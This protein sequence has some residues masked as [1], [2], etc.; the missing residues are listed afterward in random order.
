MEFVYHVYTNPL[1]PFLPVHEQRIVIAN[2]SQ[3]LQNLQAYASNINGISIALEARGRGSYWARTYSSDFHK[4]CKKAINY[5]I[6]CCMVLCGK[7]LASATLAKAG[8]ESIGTCPRSS[9]HTS[10]LNYG[11][12]Q[13]SI[14]APHPNYGIFEPYG[15]GLYEVVCRTYWVQW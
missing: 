14:H 13:L 12:V 2:A 6:K 3:R 15:S 9:W 11:M 4:L 5:Q 10:L 7:S 8:P 1:T